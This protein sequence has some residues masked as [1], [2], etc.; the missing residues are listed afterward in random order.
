MNQYRSHQ[1]ALRFI[2]SIL[3]IQRRVKHSSHEEKSAFTQW[4]FPIYARSLKDQARKS[5]Y[6]R[7]QILDPRTQSKLFCHSPITLYSYPEQ[8][9]NRGH[10]T[11]LYSF[12]PKAIQESAQSYIAFFA[13]PYSSIY[14]P[15]TY[16]G[17]IAQA[18]LFITRTSFPRKSESLG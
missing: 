5:K 9:P 12:A 17:T 2:A 4:F 16:Y 15:Y 1:K 10:F 18:H 6:P 11:E 14:A 13:I 7:T 8:Q 3:L